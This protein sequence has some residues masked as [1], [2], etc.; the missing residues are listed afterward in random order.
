ML[1]RL[2]LLYSVFIKVFNHILH[3]CVSGIMF[4]KEVLLNEPLK[5][6]ARQEKA[7][8]V[9]WLIQIK[10]DTNLDFFLWGYVKDI[11]YR[12][13]VRRITDLKQRI[14]NAIATIDEAMLQRTWLEIDYRLDV[15]RATNGA[16]V[17]VY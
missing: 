9:A 15:L 17:E 2:V 10:L 4:V 5:M 3:L 7:Q 12:T 6:A 8:C 14:I 1:F 13:Q 11:V 16:H